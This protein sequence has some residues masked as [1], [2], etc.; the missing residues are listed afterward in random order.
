MLQTTDAQERISGTY[1]SAFQFPRQLFSRR[2]NKC[3]RGNLKDQGEE[4]PDKYSDNGGSML[5][6]VQ[7]TSLLR[8]ADGFY[9]DTHTEPNLWWVVTSGPTK[10]YP[11]IEV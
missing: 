7:P 8:Q 11:T 1:S 6:R 3:Q 4:E 2:R 10:K 5:E 9:T